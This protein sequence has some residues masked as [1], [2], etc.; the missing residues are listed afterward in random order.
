MHA[1]QTCE[2]M[3]LFRAEECGILGVC[4]STATVAFT[5]ANDEA[6]RGWDLRRPASHAYTL[7]TGNLAVCGLAWHE[8]TSSLLV[9]ANNK[10]A[11]S[12]GK[13]GAVYQYGDRVG[14]EYD[15]QHDYGWPKGAR[16]HKSYFE[17]RF[18]LSSDGSCVLQYPFDTG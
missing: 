8:A 11:L 10:H 17:E 15:Y 9:A 12:Y 7:S 1:W 14:H 16:H 18:D 3:S 4:T 5:W 2:P 6:V 13:Y